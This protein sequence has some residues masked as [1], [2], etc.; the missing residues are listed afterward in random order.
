[1]EA[2]LQVAM[3]E[4]AELTERVYTGL[5]LSPPLAEGRTPVLVI[6]SGLPGSGKTHFARLLCQAG[7]LTYIGSDP[8]RAALFPQPAYTPQENRVVFDVVDALLWRLLRQR[9]HTLYDA[10]NLSE[11]RRETLRRLA[12]DAGARPLTILVTAPQEVIRQRLATRAAHANPRPGDSQADY[13]VYLRL[14]PRAERIAHEH[15]V[16]DTS[17]DLT[18]AL[19]RVLTAIEER[20]HPRGQ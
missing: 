16:V 6:M 13:E 20:S 1:M 19:E 4:I 3:S 11:T 7:S 15:I 8:V 2:A 9:R 5:A 12:Y 14:A 17:T 18:P 10:V